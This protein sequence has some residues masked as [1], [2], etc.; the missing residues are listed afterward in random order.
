MIFT[1]GLIDQFEDKLPLFIIGTHWKHF[2]PF[3][4]SFLLTGD[5]NESSLK[6]FC[7]LKKT[8]SPPHP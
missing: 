1:S 3:L 2:K 7:S 5:F 8:F 4:E 6:P